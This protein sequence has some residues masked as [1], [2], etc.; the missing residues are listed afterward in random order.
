[1]NDLTRY[2]AVKEQMKTGD[3]LQWRSNSTVGTLI[4]WWTGYEVSHSSLILRL[5]EYEGE[6][7]H[8][9]TTEAI[10]KGT[11]LSLLSRRLEHFDGNLWWYP[12]K[13]DWDKKRTFIG[14]MALGLIGIKYDYKNL[15]KQIFGKISADIEQLWCSEYVYVCYG[16]S[17]IAPYPGELSK[18]GI[19]KEGVQLI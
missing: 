7:R 6:E 4:C 16:Y 11:V 10:S 12:L 15:L 18:L 8:R 2:R 17:G 14:E 13:E 5:S 1:M 19:H 9:F 3:L